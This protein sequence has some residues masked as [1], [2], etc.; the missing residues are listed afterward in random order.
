[1]P[2]QEMAPH[3]IDRIEFFVAAN[4]GLPPR[5]IGKV[6]SGGELSRIS[7]AIQVSA[8]DYKATP[9]LIFAAV[10]TGIGGRVAEIVGQKLRLLASD[11][12]VFCV[13]HLPQV[14][15]Q[16]HN[17]LL[18]EKKVADHLTHTQVRQI[19]APERKQEIA[20]M[21]GGIRITDQTLAHAE[22]MLKETCP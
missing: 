3:G 6:A 11:R 5:P 18:V 21:L 17:H 15:A 2:D 4:P 22:E 7:L 12:Q 20:R 8:I 14:A 13:T 19:A 9:T 16:G 10:D 1:M